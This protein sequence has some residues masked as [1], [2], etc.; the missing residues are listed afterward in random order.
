MHENSEFKKKVKDREICVQGERVDKYK[1]LMNKS[2]DCEFE[3]ERNILP[4]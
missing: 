4:S 3:F 2:E 1:Y